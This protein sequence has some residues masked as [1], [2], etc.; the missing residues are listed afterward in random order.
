MADVKVVRALLVADAALASVVPA[1]RIMAGHIPQG[2]T[3]PAVAV[4]HVSTVRY[5]PGATALKTSRVQ[6]TVMATSYPQQKSVLA[7]VVA[8]LPKTRGT[9]AGVEVDSITPD[10]EGPDQSDA[11][12]GIC[13]QTYDVIVRHA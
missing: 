12:T 11:D 6:V 4:S 3:L 2:A 1:A 10:I 8:A 7:L 5:Q 9:V 13:F